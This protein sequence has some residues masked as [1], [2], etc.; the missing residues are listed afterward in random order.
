MQ[1]KE[2]TKIDLS[3]IAFQGVRL[4][5]MLT[6][7][8]SVYFGVIIT[9]QGIN[10]SQTIAAYLIKVVAILITILL[11]YG[12]I[13]KNSLA[14]RVSLLL[15]LFGLVRDIYGISFHYSFGLSPSY[16]GLST[17]LIFLVALFASKKIYLKG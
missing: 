17:T 5:A 12:L 8:Y 7:I 4:I 11:C 14:W 1:S 3:Q 15:T 2:H 16:V 10:Y 6:A 13:T 9:F